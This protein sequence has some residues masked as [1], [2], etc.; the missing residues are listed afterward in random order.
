[1][2]CSFYDM[3]YINIQKGSRTFF[4]QNRSCAS[5]LQQRHVHTH[6]RGEMIIQMI[7]VPKSILLYN[8]WNYILYFTS[9]MKIRTAAFQ[10]KSSY[11]ANYWGNYFLSAMF[12]YDLTGTNL[13]ISGKADNSCEHK[14]LLSATLVLDFKPFF[15][16]KARTI[17][18]FWGE[19]GVFT[20]VSA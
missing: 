14:Y 18:I 4:H 7:M 2:Q 3:K 8:F 16:I 9:H 13:L 11:Q 6:L 20:C 17:Y 10:E 1:M 19:G 15:T 12:C 5:S